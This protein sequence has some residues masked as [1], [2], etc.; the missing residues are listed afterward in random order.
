M[1]QKNRPRIVGGICEFCGIPANSCPHF[2]D[3]KVI[4]PVE[5][6][7]QNKINRSKICKDFKSKK[8]ADI[9][10]PHHDQHGHLKNLLNTLPNDRFNIIIVSGGSFAQNC[11]RGAKA[12]ITDKLIFLN[13]DTLP[14]VD[15]IEKLISNLDKH[16]VVGCAQKNI[17]SGKIYYGVSFYQEHNKLKAT[18]TT[19]PDI[20]HFP[21]GFCIAFK[22]KVFDKFKFDEGFRNGGED[23]DLFFRLLK[24]NIDIFIDNE[25]IIDH[26]HSQSTGRLAHTWENAKLL[27]KKWPNKQIKE[28]FGLDFDFDKPKILIAC[29][30]LEILAGSETF[31]ITLAQEFHK[32]GYDVD[33]FTL[34]R[35]EVAN[36]LD[37]LIVTKPKPEY[38]LIIISH[39]TT[40]RALNNIKGYKIQVCHGIY[41]KLEQPTDGVNTYVA[42]SEEVQDHLKLLGYES[43]VIRNPIDLDR[44]N[45]KNK[46]H[47]KL[48]S[49]LSIS[50]G[51]DAI[52][53]IE[54]ACNKLKVKFN[55]AEKINN[56][57]TK[58]NKSDIVVSLGRGAMESMA[59]GRQVIVYDTRQYTKYKTSD[60]I[61]T[62]QNVKKIIT[63]NIS[64]RSYKKTMTVEKMV[65]E[66]KKY[67]YK[68][69]DDM[70]VIAN[71]YFDSE[72]IIKKYIN[73]YEERSEEIE[74][75]NIIPS[76]Q[77]M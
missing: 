25:I 20:V 29:N 18:L 36:K 70:I 73:L 7:S 38:D 24:A 46:P 40:V 61:I 31:N 77:Y 17:E 26:Y 51:K 37:N 49:V 68:K 41:P 22:R 45:R 47:K 65:T 33:V 55:H 60:G 54:E 39:N 32:Q 66:L 9:I 30:H 23:S 75:D 43:T 44:F 1:E 69:S 19:N 53:L 71:K 21:A 42:M 34:S 11:N 12:A 35:G 58:I 13:D 57:E 64:G 48:T 59:C 8:I 27:R 63:H 67:D 15:H 5:N 3:T 4:D 50:K 76:Y 56:I 72:K 62:K 16:S 2:C 74:D 28:L 14:Q 6:V 52:D 10:I